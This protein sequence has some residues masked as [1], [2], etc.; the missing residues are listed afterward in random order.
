MTRV[1]RSLSSRT[2]DLL[3]IAIILV[4]GLT[5]GRQVIDWWRTDPT[6]LARTAA[7][8]PALPL[9][10]GDNGVPVSL[11]FGDQPCAIVRRTFRGSHVDAL[12]AL[13]ASCRELLDRGDP[14]QKPLDDGERRLLDQLADLHA[15]E[16]QPGVWQ[17][18]QVADAFG[19]VIGT[20]KFDT[21]AAPRRVVCWGILFPLVDDEWVLFTFHS[22]AGSTAAGGLPSPPVP[23]ESRRVLALRDARG[24]AIMSL[25]GTGQPLDWMRFYEAWFDRQAWR[26][27]TD[28]QHAGNVRQARFVPR[29]AGS[30]ATADL[31]IVEDPNHRLTGLLTIT[32]AGAAAR[33]TE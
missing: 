7:S 1:A 5:L 10:W 32:L 16:E 27:L 31:Q 22:A 28:W 29:D 23:P 26:R 18:Y 4:G 15:D 13:R 30:V 21:S 20:R 9:T 19:V 2:T 6:E 3:G 24:G 11:E 25:A 12:S 8:Q 14:P 17:M 33:E